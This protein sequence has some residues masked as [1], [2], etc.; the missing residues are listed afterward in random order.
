VPVVADDAM[1]D[2]SVVV[3]VLNA[4]TATRVKRLPGDHD[5]VVVIFVVFAIAA[6]PAR[7]LPVLEGTVCVHTASPLCQVAR[8]LRAY[9]DDSL[10]VLLLFLLADVGEDQLVRSILFPILEVRDEAIIRE[11]ELV[12]VLLIESD[13]GV[14]PV[15]DR[16]VAHLDRELASA[17][18]AP[19]S[20][21]IDPDGGDAIGEKHLTVELQPFERVDLDSEIVENP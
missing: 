3:L 8:I 17:V 7:G 5:F 2:R 12:G 1:A 18:E 11:V 14:Q 10:G 20:K 13:D 19:R 6:T 16:G 9:S 15:H 4:F 21:L